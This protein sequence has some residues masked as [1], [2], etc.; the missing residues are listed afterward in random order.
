MRWRDENKWKTGPNGEIDQSTM[1]EYMSIILQAMVENYNMAMQ[2]KNTWT[3]LQNRRQL[4]EKRIR[5][6]LI[7]FINWIEENLPEKDLSEIIGNTYDLED[8]I[9]LRI[10]KYEDKKKSDKDGE[11]KELKKFETWL[12]SN[13]FKYVENPAREKEPLKKYTGMVKFTKIVQC[14]YE[15]PDKP[16]TPP[17]I[18]ENG[19]V[20]GEKVDVDDIEIFV[21]SDDDMQIEREYE[22]EHGWNKE[23]VT[24]SIYN[25]VPAMDDVERYNMYNE[26]KAFEKKWTEL[27]NKKKVPGWY[28]FDPRNPE[29]R[30]PG[31]NKMKEWDELMFNFMKDQ[32][33]IERECEQ[34]SFVVDCAQLLGIGGE[35]IVIRKLVEERVDKES[36]HVKH[37]TLY[38][39]DI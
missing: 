14:Q 6:N 21:Y 13:V 8:N 35:A 36:S 25:S 22:V 1:N 15:G 26:F 28:K 23:W 29:K 24:E 10:Q 37:I 30:P 32:K 11:V 12:M 2:Y 4:Y 39:N 16:W 17:E 19:E 34:S 20:S 3:T 33:W 7:Y 5:R 31:H 9:L 27:I 18:N 38:I